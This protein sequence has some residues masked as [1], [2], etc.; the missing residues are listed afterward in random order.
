M[1]AGQFIAV[2]L[3]TGFAAQ[4]ELRRLSAP[5]ELGRRAG[6]A[7]VDQVVMAH[8]AGGRLSEPVAGVPRSQ[9]A[10]PLAVPRGVEGTL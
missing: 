1:P 4:A 5:G 6:N 3:R 9:G 2:D 7:L 10:D 8:S